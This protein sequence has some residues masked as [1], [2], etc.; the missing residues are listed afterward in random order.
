MMVTANGK[1]RTVDDGETVSGLLERLGLV[2]DR[3]VIEHNGEP[4]ERDRFS[5]TRLR[6][7]DSL[8]IA[9]MVGGG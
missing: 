8:E 1:Q 3:V 2:A 7:G 5:Q 9:Q 4:L 6:P